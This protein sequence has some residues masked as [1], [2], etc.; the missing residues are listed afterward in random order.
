LVQC[1][2]LAVS[3]CSFGHVTFECDDDDQCIAAGGE[4]GVCLEDGYCGY[5]DS[6][7][8]SGLRYGAH[9][10]AEMTG[11]CVDPGPQPEPADPL[12]VP[13][14]DDPPPA[15]DPTAG[16]EPADGDGGTGGDAPPEDCA[17]TV[18]T[19]PVSVAACTSDKQHDPAQCEEHAGSDRILVDTAHMSM[20]NARVTSYLAFE[21]GA[22]M[23]DVRSARLELWVDDEDASD[24]SGEIWRVTAFDESVLVDEPPDMM[25][26]APLAGDQ[27]GVGAGDHVT[28]ELDVA[29]VE[30]AEILFVAIVPN[31]DDGL[32][33]FV[34][35]EGR[36]PILHVEHCE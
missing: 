36:S 6:W 5:A 15:P 2:L 17:L 29:G 21:P 7:C 31:S 35:A 27:G 33:Y 19:V 8:E 9:A 11:L 10:A 14:G 20:Q 22:A 1:I 13:D 25:G 3:S 18:T 23:I 34:D 12:P 16:P 28:W 4:E 24:A 30:G 26:D 32:R